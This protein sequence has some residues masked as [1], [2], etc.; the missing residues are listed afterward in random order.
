MHNTVLILTNLDQTY[1]IGPRFGPTVQLFAIISLRRTPLLSGDRSLLSS[2]NEILFFCP[3]A[4]LP[5]W[6]VPLPRGAVLPL[7]FSLTIVFWKGQFCPCFLAHL[8]LSI[9]QIVVPSPFPPHFVQ[10]N[11]DST[12][13]FIASQSSDRP[14]RPT[15]PTDR[16][17]GGKNVIF[18][19]TSQTTS[20]CFKLL[21]Y[22]SI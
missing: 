15:D 7:L 18:S 11:I 5:F 17:S 22:V 6:S 20:E 19:N 16:G 3:G 2:T 10:S 8:I 21:Y 9:H 4:D 14:T 13:L 1:Y 12:R